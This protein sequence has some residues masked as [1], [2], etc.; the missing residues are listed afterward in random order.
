MS[1][2]QIW[3]IFPNGDTGISAQTADSRV[4]RLLEFRVPVILDVTAW[5]GSKQVF[6]GLI[7]DYRR[8]ANGGSQDVW[9]DRGCLLIPAWPLA[10]RNRGDA[11]L[12]V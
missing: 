10:E 5:I 6:G 1:I 2:S 4:S 8:A 9:E 3:L 12:V 7:Q 11:P